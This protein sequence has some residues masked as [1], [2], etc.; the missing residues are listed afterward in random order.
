[1]RA[2]AKPCKQKWLSSHLR[3]N[4]RVAPDQNALTFKTG[5]WLTSVQ[6][7]QVGDNYYRATTGGRL[8]LKWYAP[9]A[10]NYGNFSHASDVWSFGI[11]LWE[12]YSFG[13]EVPYGKMTGMQVFIARVVTLAKFYRID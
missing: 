12:M 5:S 6:F 7:F 8:P 13:M 3:A 9:E 1:M 4:L 2:F 10:I 11:T